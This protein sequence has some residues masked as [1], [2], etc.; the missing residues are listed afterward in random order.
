MTIISV[1]AAV[2]GTLSGI[3]NLPQAYRIFKRKSARDIS[4]LTYGFLLA[5]AIVW[6]FYGFEKWDFPIIITN[7]IGGF[8]IGLVVIGWCIYGKKANKRRKR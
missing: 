6:I 7:I 8:N 1:L 2:F 3:A 5:G 4:I